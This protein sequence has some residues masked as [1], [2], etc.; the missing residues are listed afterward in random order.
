MPDPIPTTHRP[1]LGELALRLLL[2]L[3]IAGAFV[4][5]ALDYFDVLTP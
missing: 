2:I 4:V 3:A 1:T 5:A